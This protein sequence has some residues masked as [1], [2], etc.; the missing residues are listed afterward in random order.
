MARPC[1]FLMVLVLMSCWSTC[2]LGCDLS[3]TDKIMNETLSILLAQKK[4]FS[5]PCWKETKNF[6]CPLEEMDA[7]QIQKPQ[8]IQVLDDMT[9]QSLTLFCLNKASAAWET[10]LLETF[11]NGLYDQLR[12]LQSCRMQHVGMQEIPV[13]KYFERITA[14]LRK[15]KHSPCA[16]M[17]VRAEV[18]RAWSFSAN[19]PKSLNKENE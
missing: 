9:Q 3:Q 19:L 6:L 1:D 10:T 2:S 4:Q 15:K 5:L 16:W 12:E 7:Q 14:Y 11:C 18:W 17:V 13:K 8:V